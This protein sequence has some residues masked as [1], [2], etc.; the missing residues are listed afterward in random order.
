MPLLKPNIMSD[1][2]S[3]PELSR[4]GLAEAKI[5]M[6]S[7]LASSQSSIDIRT[8]NTNSKLKSIPERI[9]AFGLLMA[10]LS[11]FCFSIA[12]VIVRI[13]V[14]LPTIEILV[15]RSLCQF[16]VYFA[17][18]LVY[19]YNFF[20]QPGHRLDLFY[21][22]ISGTISL[23][24]V[25]IAYRLIP[26][27][28]ASTIHFASPVFVTVFAYFLLKEPLSK[29]QIITGTITLTGVFIIAK[30]EFIFGS[31]SD[32]IHEMRL[33]GIVLSVIASM[34]AAF[35]M[36][37]LR[38]LKTTPVAVV[39]MWYSFTLVVCGSTYLTIANKWIMPNTT[40]IWSLLIAIGICG[41]LDQY[42]I[43]LAF[44]YEK[45]G[46]ISVV[47]TFNIV[48]SFLWEVMLLNEDIEWTSILGACLIC[49]CVIV[50]AL[51][52]WYKESPES[53][54]KIRRKL[55]CFCPAPGPKPKPKSKSSLSSSSSSSSSSKRNKKI[56]NKSRSRDI[57][58]QSSSTVDFNI[59][60]TLD[61][62][63]KKH[64]KNG[65]NESIDSITGQNTVNSNAILLIKSDDDD[66]E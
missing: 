53:F 36:I 5:N 47:R 37:A 11:V 31:E 9:P 22:S 4:F 66:D 43:T 23:S 6:P 26:L 8:S 51:V 29:L 45:A 19:G 28:D 44:Q 48:L 7:T 17:T 32:V 57:N 30:P 54:E 35:S 46:P 38:K 42:C 52:K 3:T 16:V 24:A 63:M 56:N 40:Q 27:S 33:E 20:G 58:N 61:S 55:C 25:Y 21:R 49:S 12:S 14:S 2:L 1:I 10:I 15:W 64:K 18:T 41:I 34:T 65:S 60:T 62:T 50:L 39:V 13:L 59:A